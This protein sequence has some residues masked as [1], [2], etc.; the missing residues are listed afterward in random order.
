MVD[1]VRA[2]LLVGGL[3][4]QITHE[5]DFVAGGGD[6]GDENHVVVGAGGL[7]LGTVVAVQRVTHLVREGEHAVKGVL[8]VEKHVGVRLGVA[9]GVRA[10]ALADVLVDID[11]AVV[12]AFLQQLYIVV[13]QNMERVEHSRLRVLIADLLRGVGNDRGVHVV[14]VQLVYTEQLFAQGDVLVHLVHVRVDGVDKVQIDLDGNLGGVERRG[15]GGLI[16]ACAGEEA[17]LLELCVKRRGDGVLVFAEAVVVGLERVAA[18]HTVAALKQGDEGAVS[19]LMLHAVLV[20]NFGE[21]QLRVAEYA[22][23]ALRGVCHLA[24]GGQQGLLCGGEDVRGAA[25]DLVQAAAVGLQLRLHGVE[26]VQRVIRNGHYLGGAVRGGACDSNVG[27]HGLAAHVLIV[28]VAGVLIALAACVAVETAQAG[29][30]LVV[31]AEGLK[32]RF[33]ALAELALKSRDARGRFLERFI[34][35]KPCLVALKHV[36]EVPSEFLRDFTALGDNVL[37]HIN[38]PRFLSIG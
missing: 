16:F 23:D 13:A 32:Q 27:A 17:K 9:G 4:E 33:G 30:Y 28:V 19:E 21:A 18:E 12:E 35:G 25:A 24:R 7:I 3:A 20:L 22:A 31:K 6:L 26:Q 29:A 8:V 1:E 2:L 15:E 5:Q 34:L 36:L 38:K 37:C 14:H 11:P 10:A